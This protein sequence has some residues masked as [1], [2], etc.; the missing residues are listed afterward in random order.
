MPPSSP[1][2]KTRPIV[3][4][5]F[6]SIASAAASVSVLAGSAGGSYKRVTGNVCVSIVTIGAPPKYFEKASAFIVAEETTTFRSL[7]TS[8][9]RFKR[10]NTKSMFKL[11]SCA[12]ST[13]MTE[14]F[15]IIG[16]SFIS[17][18]RIPSV[19]IFIFVVRSV[20]SSKR[21]L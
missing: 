3:S 18:K 20:L 13:I 11:R 16:S 7:R 15:I 14:Y 12:S 2:S 19:I 8:K 17:C 4:S 21:I 1:L 9:Q 10:P 5:I 6:A